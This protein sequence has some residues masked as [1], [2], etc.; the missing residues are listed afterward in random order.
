MKRKYYAVEYWSGRSTTTGNYPHIRIACHVES[1][2]SCS[3]RQAWI[4]RGKITSD[5]SGN[6]R[7]AKTIKQLRSMNCYFKD[8]I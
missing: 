4:E 8:E 3:E 7:E 1:F 5:M 2:E 6:C